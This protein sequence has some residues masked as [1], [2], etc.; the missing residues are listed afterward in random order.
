MHSPQTEVFNAGT[1]YAYDGENRIYFAPT[2]ASGLVQYVM[3]YDIELNK[4]F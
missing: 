1:Y 4:T 2:V 3:Y